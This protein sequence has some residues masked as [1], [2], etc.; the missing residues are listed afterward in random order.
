MKPEE[1]MYDADLLLDLFEERA[2][3]MQYEGGM[4][5]Q[6]AEEKAANCYGFI[7]KAALLGWVLDLKETNNN[8]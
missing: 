5:R 3:I 7:D 6:D 4:N 8:V 2:A 1:Y